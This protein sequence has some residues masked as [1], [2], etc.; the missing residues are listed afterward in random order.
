MP[1][2]THY[3]SPV[4]G[5]HSL[6]LS[7]INFTLSAPPSLAKWSCPSVK[8]REMDVFLDVPFCRDANVG[9]VKSI[10]QSTEN[11]QSRATVVLF[12]LRSIWVLSEKHRAP[13]R[14]P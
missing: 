3:L 14:W 2:A 4:I 6:S 1:L 9:G 13:V 10:L 5:F 7:N 12:F 11:V 8:L